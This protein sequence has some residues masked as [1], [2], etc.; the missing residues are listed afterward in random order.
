MHYNDSAA[1]FVLL[2][3]SNAVGHALPM[4]EKDRIIKP[5]KNVFGLSRKYNQSFDNLQLLWSGYTS[6]D[7]NL[8][9]E[10]DNTYSVANC[11]ARLWQ[12]EINTGNRNNLPDLYI[13]HIAIG[14]QG[15][16]DGYMWSPNYEK[17][18]IPGKLG[19]VDISLTPFTNHILSLLK[20]SFDREGKAF[21]VIGIHWR[22][23]ENDALATWEV[24]LSKG[25]NIHNELFRGFCKS[26]GRNVPI[27][28]HMRASAQRCA[29]KDPRG[30]MLK[31]MN[32]IN[33]IFEE[34]SM[35]NENISVFD[36]RKCPYYMPD[37]RGNGIFLEDLVHYTAKT[38]WWVAEQIINN[39]KLNKTEK[40]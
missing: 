24:L 37:V 17:K 21:D 33:T 30:E 32:Y 35:E 34:L 19:T 38:N 39:Y 2:G 6:F 27:I 8:A 5:M 12:D 7:M 14:A 20:E 18:L 23:S 26:I 11:L 40:Y 28:L 22:G 10:Q 29:E 13:V 15:I 3:Q 31:K 36:V 16:T 25:K 4:C 9:E 1:V